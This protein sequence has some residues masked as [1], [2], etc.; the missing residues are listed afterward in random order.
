M[1]LLDTNIISELRKPKPYGAVVAWLES[2]DDAQL[3]VSAVT[4]TQ[5]QAYVPTC[6]H[7]GP[8]H[9]TLRL[10]PHGSH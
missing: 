7:V 4:L 5:T 10:H 2:V 9:L 1:Y 6:L 8:H 3:N